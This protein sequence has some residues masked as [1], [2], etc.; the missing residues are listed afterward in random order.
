MKPIERCEACDVKLVEY[1]HVINKNLAQC[2]VKMY[3]GG[4]VL[5]MKECEAKGITYN[6]RANFQK[7]R[8]WGLIK[9]V[10][11]ETTG[12]RD[13]GSWALTLRGYAFVEGKEAVQKKVWTFRGNMVRFTGEQVFIRDLDYEFY[14]KR[15]DYIADQQPRFVTDAGQLEFF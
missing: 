1:G 5:L 8:Y 15:S 14:R 13:G 11:D 2:L 10:V 6:Q 12:E 3:D 9:K 4:G 7:L